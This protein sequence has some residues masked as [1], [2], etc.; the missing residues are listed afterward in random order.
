MDVKYYTRIRKLYVSRTRAGHFSTIPLFHWYLVTWVVCKKST[1]PGIGLNDLHETFPDKRPPYLIM[2]ER[3]TEDKEI[4][5]GGTKK[6]FLNSFEG[7]EPKQI[8]ETAGE[9]ISN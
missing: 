7:T 2:V 5:Q 3:G 4:N 9:I 8:S 1:P 6:K